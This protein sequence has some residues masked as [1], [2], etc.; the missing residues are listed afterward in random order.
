MVRQQDPQSVLPD[1]DVRPVVNSAVAGQR[2][3]QRH[4]PAERQA[5]CWVFAGHTPHQEGHL[6]LPEHHQDQQRPPAED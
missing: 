4:L 1:S 5:F 2:G 3:A 6:V